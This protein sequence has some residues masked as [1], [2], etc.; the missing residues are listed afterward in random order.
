MQDAPDP[1][2][3]VL[4]TIAIGISLLALGFSGWQAITAHLAR[5]TPLRASFALIHPQ[6][7]FDPVILHNTG[8]S[9]ASEVE[10]V[11]RR[12][13][14]RAELR[15]VVVRVAGVVGAGQSVPINSTK[16]R[17][18][19]V[20]GLF[21]PSPDTPGHYVPAPDGT[22]GAIRMLEEWAKVTWTDWRGKRRKGRIRLW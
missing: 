22:P 20:V 16:E 6:N 10:I 1:T 11:L 8:G 17:N 15:E 14:A 21:V 4:S 7:H 13:L 5:T 3:I 12:P 19:F 9:A 18:P 2:A